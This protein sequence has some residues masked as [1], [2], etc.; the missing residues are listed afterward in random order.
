MKSAKAVLPCV[1]NDYSTAPC[2]T[3]ERTSGSPV[4]GIVGVSKLLRPS[5][6]SRENSESGEDSR[7]SYVGPAVCPVDSVENIDEVYDSVWMDIGGRAGFP[8]TLLPEDGEEMHAVASGLLETA[9]VWLL[10]VVVGVEE[11]P[12]VPAALGPRMEASSP[13]RIAVAVEV[14]LIAAAIVLNGRELDD[15]RQ[16]LEDSL[17]GCRLSEGCGFAGDGVR[18]RGPTAGVNERLFL[19]VP[20]ILRVEL[21]AIVV[22]GSKEDLVVGVGEVAD[23][24]GV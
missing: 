21:G 18:V 12:P 19:E 9:G 11:L 5:K 24:M 17:G 7:T 1:S 20:S 14:A 16:R 10:F 8:A 4:S 6:S 22:D 3:R 13:S 23:G 2:P 15:R